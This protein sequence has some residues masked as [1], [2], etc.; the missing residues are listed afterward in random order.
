MVLVSIAALNS[1]KGL[2]AMGETEENGFYAE[3]EHLSMF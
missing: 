3:L 1:F 2:L